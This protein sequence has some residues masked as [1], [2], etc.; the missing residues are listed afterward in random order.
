ME[1][2]REVMTKKNR[3]MSEYLD[4]I[5][6][7]QLNNDQLQADIAHLKEELQQATEDMNS[8]TKHHSKLKTVLEETENV[9][10]EMRKERDLLRSQ[11]Q[12]MQLQ[13]ESK[14]DG[15]DRLMS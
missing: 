12:D 8:M 9:S 4:E 7:L 15:D 1:A 6:N 3:E 14:A 11:V 2:V 13:L 10:E 5:K